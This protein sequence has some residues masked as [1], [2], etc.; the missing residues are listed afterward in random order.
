MAFEKFAGV[1]GSGPA[2]VLLMV[3]YLD[4]E[5]G[6]DLLLRIL[7]ILQRPHLLPA[8]R[9]PELTHG[10]VLQT[11]GVIQRRQQVHLLF[12]FL[13]AQSACLDL[14]GLV[15]TFC[16]IG[17]FHGA[18]GGVAEHGVVFVWGFAGEV[19]AELG[20]V[21]ARIKTLRPH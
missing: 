18:A 12:T 8:H 15:A 7:P 19:A 9:R 14:I 5:W 2:G 20:Y 6:V 16:P 21:D 3:A 4:V 11:R 13:R 17:H 1:Y 10:H